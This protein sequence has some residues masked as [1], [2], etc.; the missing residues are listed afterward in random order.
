M[1]RRAVVT[2]VVIAGAARGDVTPPSP[3]SDPA[4]SR[5]ALDEAHL[6]DGA[7]PAFI[8][9]ELRFAA[10]RR[11]RFSSSERQG[12]KRAVEAVTRSFKELDAAYQPLVPVPLWGVAALVRAGDARA[13]FVAKLRA[14]PAPAGLDEATRRIYLDQ[15]DDLSS[16][17]L[18]QARELWR[19]AI[20]RSRGGSGPDASPLARRW[21]ARAEKELG[22]PAAP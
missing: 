3:G 4:P 15:I 17:I 9:A 20:A 19:R 12:L 11:L 13:E 14:A 18:D 7:P 5:R 10:F 1:L 8:A 22:A 21:A 6:T 2:L 16:P